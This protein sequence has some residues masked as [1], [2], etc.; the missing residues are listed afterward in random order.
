LYFLI[1]AFVIPIFVA[2][3]ANMAWHCLHLELMGTI[4]GQRINRIKWL[5]LTKITL[6]YYFQYAVMQS[7]PG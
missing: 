5:L 7:G 4:H 6:P 3:T 2:E 1:D